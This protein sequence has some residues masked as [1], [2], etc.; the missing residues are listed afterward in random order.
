MSLANARRTASYDILAIDL[1]GT[2]LNRRGE[3]SERN[4]AAIRRARE[5]GIEIVLATGRAWVE[6]HHVLERI[7]QRDG[8]FIGAGG[9]ILSRAADGATIER[10]VMAPHL[11]GRMVGAL[12]SRGH[13]AHLL[14][15]RHA[16]GYD[17]MI[18]GAG[19]L[20]PASE[21]W[22]RTLPV[23]ARFAGGME[24]D[25]H[26]GETLRC[27]TVAT[28]DEI[29]SVAA[30]IREELGDAVFLQHWPAVTQTEAIGSGTHMLEIFNPDVDKWTALARYARERGVSPERIAA[31]G[32][33]VND[34]RMV[35]S[36]GLGIAVA[37]AVP[38]VAH[39]AARVVGH[40]EEDGVAEAITK[41]LDEGW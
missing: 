34:V 11:V 31:I 2:L 41:I 22:M 9:S 20:D 12:V 38:T 32:D 28:A 35:R 8:V 17:Y 13:L 1:D 26:P 15:D 10:S 39:S 23:A 40:H 4:V 16:T 24:A 3:V 19:V 37:N 29:A 21:W 6:S 7:E 36:A 18:V 33:G 14:K 27:G 25:E 5:E 30:A